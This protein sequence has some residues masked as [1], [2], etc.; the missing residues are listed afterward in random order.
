MVGVI[1]ATIKELLGDAYKDGMTIEEVET[2]LSG[3]KI[4]DLSS[5]DLSLIHI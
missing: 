5:G 3:K 1:M 4:V 2:A